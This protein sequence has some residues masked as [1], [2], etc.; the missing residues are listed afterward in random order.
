MPPLA[1]SAIRLARLVGTA[2]ARPLLVSGQAMTPAQALRNGVI[3]ELVTPAGLRAAA[4]RHVARG[5]AVRSPPLVG[6]AAPGSAGAADAQQPARA[7]IE[8]TLA[9]ADAAA[10]G[11]DDRALR[12]AGERLVEV[13]RGSVAR[14]MVRTLG[15]GVARANALARRPAGH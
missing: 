1:G 8:A 4:I 6:A 14:A 3:D 15:L 2:A 5:A 13:A 7:A 11:D 12:R 10:D 9:D